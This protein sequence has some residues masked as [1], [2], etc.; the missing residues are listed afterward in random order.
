MAVYKCSVCDTVFDEEKEGKKWEELAEEWNCHVCE[1]G[2]SVW[3]RIDE[4][5]SGPDVSGGKPADTSWSPD[6]YK[7]LSDELEIHRNQDLAV[8]KGPGKFPEGNHRRT[9]GFCPAHRE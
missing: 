8:G 4:K 7:R 2:K 9:E 1:S 5:A 3:Q 6:E